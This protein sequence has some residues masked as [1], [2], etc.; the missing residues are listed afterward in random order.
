[1]LALQK[2]DLIEVGC[3]HSFC[4]ALVLRRDLICCTFISGLELVDRLELTIKR[5]QA[6]FEK[7]QNVDF[8]PRRLTKGEAPF[9]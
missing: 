7:L 6:A 5:K 4:F 3:L 9:H 2:L 8:S 1:M